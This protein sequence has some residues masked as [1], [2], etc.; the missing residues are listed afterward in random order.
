MNGGA[1]TALATRRGRSDRTL[2]YIDG[3]PVLE[4]ATTVVQLEDLH[5]GRV[6]SGEAL[7]HLERADQPYRARSKA[8]GLLGARD[9]SESEVVS[10]LTMAGFGTEVV[11][12]TVQW[13]RERGYLDDE[14]FATRYA[15][16]KSR[17]GWA[18]RRIRSEL[19]RRGID[20]ELIDGA[21]AQETGDPEAA[22]RGDAALLEALRR[23]FSTQ[24]A[25][26]PGTA[27]R[28]IAGYLA[29]RGH[30]WETTDRL[31]RRLREAASCPE[32][33]GSE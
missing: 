18:A 6:V 22:L 26:D 1:I 7:D 11:T 9:R 14:R 23:R 10:R 8:V 25:C 21:L 5:V 3:E 13:L 28:R 19:L 2:L 4:L 29:R 33:S 27:T 17:G 24:M 32:E 30:D 16:E 31:T 20:R 12:G 15:A